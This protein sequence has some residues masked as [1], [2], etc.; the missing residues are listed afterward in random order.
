MEEKERKQSFIIM[1]NEI[2]KE[3]PITKIIGKP[4]KWIFIGGYSIKPSLKYQFTQ[5]IIFVGP[6]KE[7]RQMKLY[8]ETLFHFYQQNGYIS[9]FCIRK[10]KW[11]PKQTLYSVNKGLFSN[12]KFGI[13]TKDIII[14]SKYYKDKYGNQKKKRSYTSRKNQKKK[15]NMNW[16]IATQIARQNMIL[17]GHI[18]PNQWLLIK[19]DGNLLEKQ[20][21]YLSKKY[22]DII[23]EKKYNN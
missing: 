17:D 13:K 8:L 14:K 16:I 12:N 7:E 5:K 10:H 23:Q 4:K 19:K 21:Y 11:V 15:R 2:K 20:I 9:R 22:Y 6:C 18:L 1:F 3:L